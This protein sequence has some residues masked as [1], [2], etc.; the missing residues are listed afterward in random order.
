VV[1]EVAIS[2]GLGWS[3]DRT[4]F[5]FIDS[6]AGELRAFDYD[7]STGEL[8]SSRVVA[9]HPIASGGRGLFDGLCVDD[10]GCVWIALWGGGAVHRYT[11]DGTLDTVV[12]LPVE[13]PSSC[14]IDPGGTLY[15][16]SARFLMDP[17]RLP[18]QPFAGSIFGVDVGVTAAPATL[19]KALA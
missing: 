10:E 7:D 16:T 19:W 3:P 14:C 8:G 4:T 12:E 11:P 9:T 15:V 1:R 6:L 18:G 13:N 2:N 17:E 5:Y